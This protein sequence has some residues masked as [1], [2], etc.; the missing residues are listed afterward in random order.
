MGV[1]GSENKKLGVFLDGEK[2]LLARKGE[3]FDAKFK[4]L[5][6]SVE[7]ADVGYADPEYQDQRKRIYFGQ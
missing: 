6:I 3:V 4:V 2:M 7:W 1:M 5:D